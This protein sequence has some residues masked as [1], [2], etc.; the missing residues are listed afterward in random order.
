M[1]ALDSLHAKKEEANNIVNVIL[2]KSIEL[3]KRLEESTKIINQIIQN[4]KN[5][6]NL[7]S[8]LKATINSTN[9]TLIRFREERDKIHRLL[10]TVNTFYE[11]NIYHYFLK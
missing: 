7:N 8:S 2:E 3:D 5:S 1:S 9:K 10:K 6:D 4:S 11:K